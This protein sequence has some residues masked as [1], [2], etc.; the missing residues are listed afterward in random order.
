MPIRS[1]LALLCALTAAAHAADPAGLEAGYATQAQT[2]DPAFA[3]SP[4]RGER[5]FKDTHGGDWSCASCHTATP[6]GAG[7]HAVT[8]KS[9]KPMAPAANPARFSDERK[10]EKWFR[11]NCR[12][13]L[14]RECAAAEKADVI[15]YLRTVTR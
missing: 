5:F 2:A 13:V 9:I 10:V 3:V 1:T 7:R 11:R 6:A 14:D 8:D 4:A 15:A 12:D